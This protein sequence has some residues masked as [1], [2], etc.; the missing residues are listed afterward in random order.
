MI[1]FVEE[2]S[3]VSDNVRLMNL[4][5]KK[6]QFPRISSKMIKG[7]ELPNSLL[8]ISKKITSIHNIETSQEEDHS[9]DSSSMFLTKR[10]S[11]KEPE[12]KLQKSKSKKLYSKIQ[13]KEFSCLRRTGSTMEIYKKDLNDE[14]K[15]TNPNCLSFLT[16][17]KI[18][19]ESLKKCVNVE[20][21][22]I[23]VLP[24]LNTKS[25]IRESISQMELEEISQEA[26]SQLNS[27]NINYS[28]NMNVATVL[29]SV[30]NSNAYF[31]KKLNEIKDASKKYNKGLVKSKHNQ[32]RFKNKN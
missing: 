9:N 2:E 31:R 23:L 15:S 5:K 28:K 19:P 14:K 18:N 26:I 20:S 30:L 16:S 10:N 4:M 1:E 32:F 11:N 27:L 22:R 17:V 13:K 21:A 25:R 8:R 3:S 7:S 6:K 24:P 12:I 29:N